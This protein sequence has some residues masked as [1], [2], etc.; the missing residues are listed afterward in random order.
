[1][2]TE[3]IWVG[4]DDIRRKLVGEELEEFLALR[5]KYADAKQA[6]NEAIRVKA[7][8]KTSAIA[9]L[10]ALGL[11]ESEANAIVS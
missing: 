7:A 10:A 4:E 5:K 8:A 3:E 6:E 2:T 11:T 1:M 9:K